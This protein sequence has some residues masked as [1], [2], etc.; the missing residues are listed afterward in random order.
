M[1]YFASVSILFLGLSFAQSPV[2]SEYQKQTAESNPMSSLSEEYYRI[3]LKKMEMNKP[4]AGTNFRKELF[5]AS[6]DIT[7]S[8]HAENSATNLVFSLGKHRYQ[9]DWKQFDLMTYQAIEVKCQS[10]KLPEA[11]LS[12]LYAISGN[13]IF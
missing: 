9:V 12:T 13:K 5:Q 1:F 3:I 4:S 2:L 11:K 6:F 8:F 10:G 7:C